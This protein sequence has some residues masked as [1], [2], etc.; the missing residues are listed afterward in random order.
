MG[1]RPNDIGCS[2][3]SVLGCSIRRAFLEILP[4]V[5]FRDKDRESMIMVLA[6][7]WA[8]ASAS[9]APSA[10]RMVAWRRVILVM[11]L[12]RVAATAV[13]VF[14]RAYSAAS[15]NT[16]VSE[17]FKAQKPF[18]LSRVCALAVL[19]HSWG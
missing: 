17:P 9:A 13:L 6:W 4:D 8:M 12:V 5:Y 14:A 18:N 2:F 1:R 10:S 19:L 16:V 7:V 15:V 11:R 3:R